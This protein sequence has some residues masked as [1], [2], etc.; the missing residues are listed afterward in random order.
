MRMKVGRIARTGV[1][2]VLV[3][4]ALST[5]SCDGRKSVSTFVDTEKIMTEKSDSLTII[6]SL[7]GKQDYVF[8]APLF[9]NYGLAK[10][11][12][13]EFRKGIVI[14]TYNDS[15]GVRESFLVADY[16]INFKNQQMWETKGNV[17]AENKDGQTLETQQL[18]WNQ[19]TKRIYSNVDTRVTQPNG[20]VI[21]GVGFESDES[22][23]DWVFRRV[24]G[25]VYIDADPDEQTSE[26]PTAARNVPRQRP[27][28]TVLS[29]ATTSRDT[30]GEYRSMVDNF[31]RAGVTVNNTVK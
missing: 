21:T 27:Q 4:A 7:N 22:M 2:L 19:K 17:F 30:W 28:A 6:S 13:M 20:E 31:E 11:P 10:E 15:T 24:E 26:R 1:A 9:E 14:E 23:N 29:P 5:V 16:A 3:A 25:K 8:R 12:Y 18:F